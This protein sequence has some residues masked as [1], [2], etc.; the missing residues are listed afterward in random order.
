VFIIQKSYRFTSA[1][2]DRLG[3]EQDK[4]WLQPYCGVCSDACSG[5][6]LKLETSS[7]SLKEV[8]EY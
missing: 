7:L 8:E 3:I 5:G 6:V 4:Q 2:A 1:L